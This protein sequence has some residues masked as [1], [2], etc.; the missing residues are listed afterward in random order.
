MNVF[1]TVHNFFL[2]QIFSELSCSAKIG[3]P[4]KR[5]KYGGKY[6]PEWKDTF[7]GVIVLAKNKVHAH[8]NKKW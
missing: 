2:P 8:Y 7:N 1:T 3:T 6:L 4:K 5:M